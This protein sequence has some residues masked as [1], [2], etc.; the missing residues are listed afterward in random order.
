LLNLERR[1]EAL[2]LFQ[3]ATSIAPAEQQAAIDALITQAGG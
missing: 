3:Q 1:P 2:T